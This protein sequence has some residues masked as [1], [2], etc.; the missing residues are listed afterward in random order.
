MFVIGTSFSVAMWAA[1][2]FGLDLRGDLIVAPVMLTAAVLISY[3]WRRKLRVAAVALIAASLAFAA[4]GVFT[5]RNIAPFE[6]YEAGEQIRFEGVITGDARTSDRSVRYTLEARFPHEN[7]PPATIVA[8]E[9]GEPNYAAGDVIAGEMRLY[10][11]RTEATRRYHRANGIVLSGSIIPEETAISPNRRYDLHRVVLEIRGRTAA[12]IRRN[13]PQ[14]SAALVQGMVMGMRDYLEPEVYIAM[15]RSG[16]AHLL[17]VS[18]IHLN[19][20]A[21]CVLLLLARLRLSRRTQSVI[22]L[23]CGFMFLVL[24][25]FS[26]SVTRALVM[27]SVVMT[28]R[29]LSRRADTLNSVGIA[30]LVI[31]ILRPYWVLGMGIWFSAASCA[32]IAALAKRVS[33]VVQGR[34]FPAVAKAIGVACGAYLFTLP[35]LYIMNGWVPLAAP[36]VNVLISPLIPII[37]LGG[38]LCAVLPQGLFIT[39]AA[40]VITHL[41]A[42]LLTGVAGVFSSMPYTVIAFDRFWKLALCTGFIVVAVIL[43]VKH[44]NKRVWALVTAICVAVFGAFSL[45]DTWRAQNRLEFITIGEDEPV[46]IVL[47]GQ[48]A[49]MLEPPTRFD[50]NRTLRYLSFRGVRRVDVVLAPNHGNHIDSGIIRLHESYDLACVIGPADSY[51]LEMLAEALPGVPIYPADNATAEML[52]AMR[53]S[54]GDDGAARIELGTGKANT[55][56]LWAF[57]Y[58]VDYDTILPQRINPAFEPTAARLFGETRVIIEV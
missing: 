30:L 36:V 8:Y 15:Q 21:A 41:C 35:L 50:I 49:I 33:T 38:M 28:A 4:H 55:V 23:L 32:G 40:A 7:L 46:G 9:F 53:V 45:A 6:R 48:N 31:C 1:F 19:I 57:Q 18:G 52:G 54:F 3:I 17:A 29:F 34:M 16:V 39:Q 12:N 20:F 11:P 5:Q 2:Q 47:R 14:D 26:P 43:I 37:M 56:G 27:M 10:E 58:P 42:G 25:G 44:A 24:T 22:T 51:I 13:L